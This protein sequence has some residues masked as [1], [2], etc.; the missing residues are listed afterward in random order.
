[1]QL[2]NQLSQ[3]SNNQSCEKDTDCLAVEFGDGCNVVVKPQAASCTISF[4]GTV[5]GGRVVGPCCVGGKCQEGSQCPNGA[6][7]GDAAAD[8]TVGDA[9][10]AGSE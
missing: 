8:A 2:V 10:D 5:D 9:G 4:C 1:M 7:F 3:A 6:S